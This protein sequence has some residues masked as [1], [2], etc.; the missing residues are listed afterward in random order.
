MKV[1]S[2]ETR[3]RMSEAAK[4][5]CTADWR[6]KKSAEYSTPLPFAVVERMYREG[7]TQDEIASFLGV[8]QKVVW[9]FMK[10]NGIK[11]RVA[12]KR[13]QRGEKNSSWKG[14]GAS[15]NAFHNR[16]YAAR[17]KPMR[18][19]VCMK[20]DPDASYD[21]ANLTGR[22]EDIDDY[23]RMCRSCHFKYDDIGQNLPEGKIPSD[24]IGEIL[25]RRSSGE[26]LASIAKNFDVTVSAIS[27]HCNRKEVQHASDQAV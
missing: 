2:E 22:Y 21:W 24:R 17:G 6:R 20:D 9:K 19:D 14:D 10:N 12:A 26:S 3:R 27:W 7:A 11:A 4:R 18:C 15:Y 8:S 5:R 16:V 1:F 25:L 13:D 23:K